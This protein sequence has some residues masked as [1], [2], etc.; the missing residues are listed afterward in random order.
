[1]LRVGHVASQAML[2]GE[3]GTQSTLKNALSCCERFDLSQ[4]E[5]KALQ[6]EI[7]ESI[8]GY[9]SEMCDLAQLSTYEQLRLQQATVLSEY[10]FQT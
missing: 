7:V 3:N 6:Q 4:A 1:M 5:A 8:R 10:C 2:V 9:W